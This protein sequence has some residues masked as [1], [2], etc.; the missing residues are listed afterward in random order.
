[1]RPGSQQLPVLTSC[2]RQ[3]GCKRL[4][5]LVV[6]IKRHSL[7]IV[8]FLIILVLSGPGDVVFI[9][10]VVQRAQTCRCPQLPPPAVLPVG[11][12]CELWQGG[13]QVTM[14]SHQR[15]LQ[16]Q[17]QRAAFTFDCF[18]LVLPVAAVHTMLMLC[19]MPAA[20]PP[21][22]SAAAAAGAQCSQPGSLQAIC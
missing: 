9:I 3:D 20:T 12:Q 7:M 10:V 18:D 6:I 19:C 14:Q 22:T 13:Q 5:L 15:A 2:R 17:Q 16:E 1:M 8:V 11:R 21:A 4:L